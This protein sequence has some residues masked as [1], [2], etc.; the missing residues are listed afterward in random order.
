MSILAISCFQA[1]SFL[2]SGSPWSRGS[3]WFS[4][5]QRSH[6]SGARWPAEDQRGG[7][8]DE[9]GRLR[10]RPNEN[11]WHFLFAYIFLCRYV[12]REA[13]SGAA[14]A[15]YRAAARRGANRLPF[16][17]YWQLEP[18]ASPPP[19]R[20][21]GTP[22]SPPFSSSSSP[23]P[24]LVFNHACSRGVEFLGTMLIFPFLLTTPVIVEGVLMNNTGRSVGWTRDLSAMAIDSAPRAARS[25]RTNSLRARYIM[26]LSR[27]RGNSDSAE[28]YRW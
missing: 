11:A 7:R 13:S 5:V 27:Q 15:R 16:D 1:P 10:Q 28:R 25:D 19:S 12:K 9:R 8:A 4:G 14:I 26:I 17:Q 3:R 21:P 23:L 6:R 20:S 2:T 18:I 22:L 24:R